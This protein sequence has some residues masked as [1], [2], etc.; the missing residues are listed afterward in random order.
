MSRVLCLLTPFSQH[1]NHNVTCESSLLK[2]LL[3][4]HPKPCLLSTTVEPV[5]VL[6]AK[7]GLY[8]INKRNVYALVEDQVQ[9]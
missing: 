7:S 5:L 2:C 1:E 8:Y 3:M 9:T 6:E 4:K